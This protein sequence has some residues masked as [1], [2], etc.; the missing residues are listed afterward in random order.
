MADA[1]LS[2]YAAAS[3]TDPQ[4]GPGIFATAVAVGL[5]FLQAMA[6]TALGKPA[7]GPTRSKRSPSCWMITLATCGAASST[8]WIYPDQ[9]PV[10]DAI[11]ATSTIVTTFM[12]N[13]A[14][15]R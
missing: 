13:A 3:G 1:Q 4:I 11:A 15:T 7:I 9:G 14:A 12:R 5:N 10:S 8:R 6:E 2:G